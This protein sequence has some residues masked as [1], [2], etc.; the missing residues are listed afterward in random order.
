MIVLIGNL[1]LIWKT[2]SISMDE[3]FVFD[4]EG[5]FTGEVISTTEEE[6]PI[7]DSLVECNGTN[8]LDGY[9]ASPIVGIVHYGV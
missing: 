7:L 9:P 5:S 1:L 8:M 6:S 2:L 3:Y 4:V